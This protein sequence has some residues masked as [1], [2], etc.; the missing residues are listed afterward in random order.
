LTFIPAL[1]DFVTLLLN[2]LLLSFVFIKMG[3]I[4]KKIF[5]L[6][7]F[8]QAFTAQS[9]LFSQVSDKDQIT[10]TVHCRNAI[11][12]SYALYRPAQYDNKKSWPVILIFD[13]AARGK[14]GVSTFIE[15]GRKYG[16]ILACSNNSRNGPLQDNF[17]AAATMFQD[18]E[19]RFTV[20]QKRIYAAGFS[21]GSRFAMAFAVKEKKI[22]GVIGCGAGLPNDRNY[23]P[24]GNTD[25]L[26]Y[27][28]A[29]TRDMNYL[30]M[31]DLLGF[32]SSKTRVISYFRTF[33][34][35]HQWPGSDLIT[36]AVEWLV[37]QTMNRKIIPADRTFLSYVENKTQNLINSQLSAGNQADAIMY[38][39]FA[40]R[41]FQG[42]PFASGMTKLL[43]DSEKSAEYQKAIRKWNKM[44]ATEQEKK[45][46]YLN[47][48]SEIVNSGSLPDS[49]SVWWRN[50]TRELIRLRDKGSPEISQMASRVLNFISILCSEQGTSYY[51][52]RFYAQAAFMFEICTLSDSEN[53]NNYYNLARSLAGS[54][55]SKESVD[56][57]SAAM[58]HGFNSRKTV[59]S[60]PAFG[61]IRG[62]T[63]YKALILKMK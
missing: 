61:K 26:Y 4:F 3:T 58:N 14:T 21:G 12:Q 55:K 43:T 54:G 9:L 22:S 20:D 29:G 8:L 38:M 59:E 56:A 37:L 16:F 52:N 44:A 42:T 45:E 11:G 49:A 63:R 34:G 2:F 46:K 10:D 51:R 5:S 50:E 19:E 41:D 25:F 15:A 13:P 48:L 17:A 47:Y 57:L 35:G 40:A 33:P 1:R 36:E 39:R 7:F 18:V 27:G 53:P 60:D 23:L 24:S 6:F 31:H 32:F 30:E 28:L 62:D